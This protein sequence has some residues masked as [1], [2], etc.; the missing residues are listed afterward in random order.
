MIDWLEEQCK[1]IKRFSQGSEEISFIMNFEHKMLQFTRFS[2]V[3]SEMFE[4]L[5]V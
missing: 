2:R 5:L 4:I 1:D 3:N